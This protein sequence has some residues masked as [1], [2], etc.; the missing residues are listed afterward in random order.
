MEAIFFA[1]DIVGIIW[2]LY[3]AIINDDRKPGSPTTG[4]FAYRETIQGRS[5]AGAGRPTAGPGRPAA[6]NRRRSPPL[7]PRNR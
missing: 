4:L 7:P 5:A 6:D 1:V 2:L 3:W